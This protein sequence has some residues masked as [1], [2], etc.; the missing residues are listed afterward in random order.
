MEAVSQTKTISRFRG[1]CL[2][3][4]KY[5][6]GIRF[7]KKTKVFQKNECDPIFRDLD[8]NKVLHGED[9]YIKE[10]FLNF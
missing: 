8:I 4:K 5:L 10:T 3:K 6:C 9:N 2:V 7:Y 1:L